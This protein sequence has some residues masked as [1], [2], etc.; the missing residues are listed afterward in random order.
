[1]RKVRPQEMQGCH[2]PL[3]R[4]QPPLENLLNGKHHTGCVDDN[5][6]SVSHRSSPYSEKADKA[7]PIP[8]TALHNQALWCRLVTGH[9]ESG[10]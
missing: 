1:M 8:L 3:R 9:R 6:R 4:A 2:K 10:L 7:C 5:G